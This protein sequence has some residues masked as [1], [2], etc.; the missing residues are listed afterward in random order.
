MRSN[1]DGT[2]VEL[3]ERVAAAPDKG[4]LFNAEEL[5]RWPDEAVS[6]LTSHK[7]LKRARLASSAIC[8]GCER[9]CAMPVHTS[10][11]PAN[12]AAFIVCDKRSDTNRV[13]VPI[14]RL[15]QWKAS[16]ASIADLLSNL[17]EI[18][19]PS[20]N[21]GPVKRSEIGLFKGAKHSSPLVLRA[22]DKLTLTLAGHSVALADVL[23]LDGNA[24]K[25]DRRA[26][27]QRVDDP[28]AGAGDAESARR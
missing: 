16:H 12:S 18:R 9:E 17:L 28:I 15:V 14:S 1:S 24:F 21:G 26:L 6:V 23:T 3:F 2:L 4:A 5:A 13:A 20:A 19:R 22:V 8:P 10:P 27:T 11:H 7:V 25:V